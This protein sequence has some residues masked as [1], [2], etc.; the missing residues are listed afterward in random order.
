MAGGFFVVAT[1][2]DLNAGYYWNSIVDFL[3]LGDLA[4][5]LFK[6]LFFGFIIASVGCFV[7]M[8]T[9]GGAEDVGAAAKKT[10][11]VASVLILISDFFLT[12]LFLV[13]LT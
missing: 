9:E 4:L 1:A 8:E 7:G 11:V 10:V 13:V 6:P 5:G 12:K 3:K 2:T